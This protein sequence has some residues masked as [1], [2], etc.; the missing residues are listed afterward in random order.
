MKRYD[1]YSDNELLDLMKK[2]HEQALSTLYYRYWDK[3]LTV[4]VHRLDDITVA[5]ECVQDLFC[6]L[7]NRRNE[8]VLRFSLATYLSVAIKYQVIKQMDI[9]YR[10]TERNERYVSE[11]TSSLNFPSAD[12]SVLEKE[13]IERIAG[14]VNRLPDKCRIVFKM[15]REEG[16]SNKHIAAELGIA[17]K[18]VEAHISKAL[19]DLRTDLVKI[20]PLILFYLFEK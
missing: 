8:L 13:M 12:E 7:W 18:T 9:Q 5:E 11:Y 3:L 19:K 6:S 1:A 2:D 14:A 16:M 17:E 15:S 20:S 4:A 10:K